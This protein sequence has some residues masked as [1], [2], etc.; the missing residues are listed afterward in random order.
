[1]GGTGEKVGGSLGGASAGGAE[2]IRSSADPRKVS[3]EG[4]TET[5]AELGQSGSVNTGQ[6]EFLIRDGRGVGKEDSIGVTGVYC[7]ADSRGV[8]GL[9]GGFILIRGEGT[10][11]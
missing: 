11:C 4:R 5:G 6:G 1:M 7:R 3:F 2:V 8:E 9:K 10:I